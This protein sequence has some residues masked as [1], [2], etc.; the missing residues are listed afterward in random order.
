MDLTVRVAG[1]A[2]QGVVTT[3]SLLVRAFA[4]L[5]LHVLATRSYMSRIHGGLNWYDIRIGDSELFAPAPRADF[6]VALTDVAMQVL[7]KHTNDG[8][9]LLF[10][11]PDTDGAISIDL[12]ALAKETGGDKRYSNTV[13]AGAVFSLLGYDLG[14]LEEVLDEMFS[15]K[16]QEVVKANQACARRGE[17]ETAGKADGLAAPKQ[18]GQ[19]TH[20]YDGAGAIGLSAAVSGVKFATAYPMTPG[21]ATYDYLAG[22]SDEYGIVLEQAEDEIA[23]VNMACGAVYAGVPA[24]TMTSGGGFALMVEGLSLAGMME[25]PILV[26]I[27]QRPGPATGLPTRTCQQDLLFALHAGHGEFPRAIFAPGSV[28]E[29]Y[30]VTRVALQTAHDYQTPV[31]L[32]TDQFLQDQEQSAE[33]LDASPR[34]IDRRIVTD[35]GPDYVRY[36]V[37]DSGVS[38]RAVPGGEAVV[39]ADS[40][41]HKA[42]GHLTEDLDRHM[43]QQ[44]K[45]MR[46]AQAM[47]A[48]AL[49][50][51]RYGPEEADTL[52]VTW[53]S[54]YGPAR[55]AVD[56]LAQK[57]QPVAMLHFAQVWPINAEAA[58]A[59]IGKPRRVLC[60]EAN[61]TGQFAAVLRSIGL[62]GEC[63]LIPN[64]T[65]L[66]FTGE[67]IARGVSP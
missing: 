32:L 58:R 30:D 61:Q 41:A 26:L 56:L 7:R 55:E 40:H 11:G 29:C 18:G 48:E 15:Q 16:G 36:S 24:M 54:T 31:I 19:P 66:A 17:A 20:M 57:G 62:L 8:A 46:K 14:R 44:D 10:N 50:P 64:Y 27:G 47:A 25:L 39:I 9:V 52:L 35:T 2:G 60:V 34:P 1:E 45:R 3:G 51:H 67:Q 6:L 5:G 43:E 53:G 4:G 22:I 65:G 59:A 42:D 13:A 21:T 63:E 23:A 38:P 12:E 33:L 49:T 28:Q 37:T